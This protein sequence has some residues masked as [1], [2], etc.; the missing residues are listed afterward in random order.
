MRPWPHVLTI[1]ALTFAFAGCAGW[2]DDEALSPDLD[3]APAPEISTAF[4]YRGT[5]LEDGTEHDGVE[6]DDAERVVE[7]DDVEGEALRP[8]FLAYGRALGRAARGER[9]DITPGGTRTGCTFAIAEVT[10]IERLTRDDVEAVIGGHIDEIRACYRRALQNDAS[11]AGRGTL[12][13][14]IGEDGGVAQAGVESTDIDHGSLRRCIESKAATWTFPPPPG[15][16][17]SVVEY[18]FVFRDRDVQGH[19]DGVA[20]TVRD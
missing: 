17:P 2:V 18:P 20:L 9:I 13:M 14:V 15:S 5:P 8:G 11:I 10:V 19:P 4:G 6:R 1:A 7:E 3:G 12:R 16:G